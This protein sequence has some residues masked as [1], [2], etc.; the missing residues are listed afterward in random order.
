M[1]KIAFIF[2]GQGS[3][4][5]GMGLDLY[6]N[7]SCA[8][9]VY[10]V[11]DN[12]LNKKISKI[13]FEGTDEELKATINA[14]SAIVTTSI[15]A[16]KAFWELCP[17]VKPTL[18]LGHSLGEY[19]AMYCAGVMNLETTIKICRG[20]PIGILEAVIPPELDCISRSKEGEIISVAN[21]IAPQKHGNVYGLNYYITSGLTPDAEKI[22]NNFL[23]L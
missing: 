2:P 6:E 7:F 14:Q 22:I 12:V 1:N 11:A 20:K 8:K 15:A 3:Q 18:A 21:L 10:D 17:E 13:C 23:S 19:C 9:N 16:L 4:S 5:K